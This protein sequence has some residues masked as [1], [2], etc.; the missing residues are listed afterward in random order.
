VT[1]TVT[2]PVTA[3]R[4]LRWGAAAWILGVSQYLACQL[5]AAN[6]WSTPYSWKNNFISDLGNTACGPFSVPHGEPAYVCSPAHTLMNVSFVLAG[7]LTAVGALLLRPLWRHSRAVRAGVVLWVIAGFGKIIVGLVPENT[8]INLHL[9]GAFNLPLGSIAILLLSRASGD[10]PKPW[11]I[12][13]VLLAC[14]GL[15][16]TVLSIAGQ[17]GHDAYLGTG[18]GGSERLAGY[19][20]NLWC[21]LIGLLALTRAAAQH[22]STNLGT[23]AM[24]R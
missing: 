1:D 9:L 22:G 20:A 18:V 19:P 16:G 15:F 23:H 12:A 5:I 17:Q 4:R 8:N 3:A 14:V 24:R 21:L 10:L 11:R 7:V 13:G 2:D 6:R